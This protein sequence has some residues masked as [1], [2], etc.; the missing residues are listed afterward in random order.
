MIPFLLFLCVGMAIYDFGFKPFWA[1]TPGLVFWMGLLLGLLVVLMAIRL[2][3]EI[4][5]KKK[6]SAKIFPVAGWFFLVVLTFYVLPGKA[7]AI[8]NSSQFLFFKIFLYTGVLLAFIIEASYLL[9]FIYK[10]KVSPAL[11]FVGSFGV[12]ILLGAFLLKLPN[13][14]FTS[15]SAFE[16]LF[17]STS[18]VCVTGLTAVDTASHFTIFGRCIILLLIQAGALG[19]MTFAGLFAYAVTGGSSLKTQ[20]AI[21]DVVSGRDIGNIV[22]FVSKVFLVT[23]LFET[24]GAISI[25]FS[26]P[27]EMFPRQLDRIFFSIFHSI[28]AFC[29]AGFSTLPQGLYEP[30]LRYNYTLQVFIA[31]LVI[32]GGM[33]FPIVFNLYRYMRVKLINFFLYLNKNPRRVHFPRLLN[34]NSRLALVVSGVLLVIGFVFYMVFEQN[35]TLL[36]HDTLWGKVV[37]SFFGSVTPRTAGFNTVDIGA[38]SLPMVMI[39]LLLMWI[40][41]SPGST[42]GGIK[43]TTIGVAVLNMVSVLRGK[44]RAEFA[45]SEISQNSIRRSFA[46]IL[47]SLLFIGIAIFLISVNDSD[48][49]LIQIAFEVF[50]A[51]STVGLSRGITQELSKFSQFILMITMFVGRVGTI[52][53]MVAFIN[54]TRPLHYRY[55]KEEITF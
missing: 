44:D 29:N 32:L 6:L 4:I 16:A 43:T 20:L 48:K 14:T 47:M 15:I 3:P 33:G 35:A 10:G 24:I 9:Q 13:A 12:F 38:L 49:G 2:V 45:G 36:A 25:Y 23:F 52:T 28:S 54:Q 53:L 11:L 8:Q 50:S 22:R 51:F 41:A 46:V 37:T 27:P 17:T 55:P 19:I 31:L 18:A 26:V 1:R 39:Y 34:L 21:R 42:G 5:K 7:N 40:G 30:V